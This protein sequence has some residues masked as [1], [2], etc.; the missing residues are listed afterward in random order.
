MPQ[1]RATRTFQNRKLGLVRSGTVKTM[2]KA[3]ADKLNRPHHESNPILVPYA[4]PSV[5]E[6]LEPSKNA[7]IPGA[8]HVGDQ[9]DPD[10]VN[11]GSD[12][13]DVEGNGGSDPEENGSEETETKESTG[14]QG[15]GRTRRSSSSRQ[16]RASNR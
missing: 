4:G 1:Y 13:E 2:S 7:A 15:G 8:P 12:P 5:Q 3:D 9:G 11:A 14:R 16:G 6:P 10:N